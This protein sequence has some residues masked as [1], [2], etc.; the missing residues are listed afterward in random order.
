MPLAKCIEI[1]EPGTTVQVQ[2]WLCNNCGNPK[3][4]RTF[5][6]AKD[7]NCAICR[8]ATRKMGVITTTE[9]KR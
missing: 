6:A 5:V 8:Q 2:L 1:G 3:W 4:Y 9:A 7:H